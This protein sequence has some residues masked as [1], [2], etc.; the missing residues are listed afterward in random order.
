MVQDVGRQCEKSWM[1][2]GIE[3]KDDDTPMEVQAI[4]EV[5]NR[6]GQ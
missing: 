1:R 2:C 4:D 5:V 6:M 3:L